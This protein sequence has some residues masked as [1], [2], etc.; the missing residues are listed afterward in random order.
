M[1]QPRRR[2]AQGQQRRPWLPKGLLSE[3]NVKLSLTLSA[4]GAFVSTVAHGHIFTAF[5]FELF[6]DNASVGLVESVAGA[7]ALLTAVPVGL[8]VD[9]V[10]RSKLLRCSAAVGLLAAALGACAVLL[11]PLVATEAAAA[12]R[13]RGAE[14]AGPGRG[15]TAL[16]LAS[17]ALWGAFFNT[18]TSASAALFADSVPQGSRRRD[19]YATKSTLSLMALSAGPLLSLVCTYVLGNEWRLEQMS[20]A[21]LPGFLAMPL[22]CLLLTYFEDVKTP[23]LD[24]LRVGLMKDAKEK[25]PTADVEAGAQQLLPSQT[26]QA[27]AVPYLILT[28]ELIT[29]VGA[30]MTVKFFGLWFKNVF[31]F[32][33]A[34]LAML[35]AATPM[36]IAVAVQSLQRAA[37]ACPC[38]PVPA[39]LAF[40]VSSVGCLLAM[41][42]A[43][44]WRVLVALHLLR[45]ALANCKEPL[46][47]A[48]LADFVPSSQRGR[49][50]AVHSLTGMTWTGSAALGG[51]LCDRYGYGKTFVITACLYLLAALFWLPLI[52]L[53]P[54]EQKKA[55]DS[56][57]E[58]K[59]KGA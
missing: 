8:A 31:N 16:L 15:Y 17:L 45:T 56:D 53:V 48:I 10:A 50:N 55:E 30:G 37:R 26:P 2:A 20:Y 19:L 3:T 34:G 6:G 33:P 47:R 9:K 7:T 1:L 42:W 13:G 51:V 23:Q 59:A 41:T 29:S 54:K 58:E 18:A 40:W 22:M 43:R 57:V 38:G 27:R 49:W 21:L 46:A 32:S 12:G 24:E 25:S 36:A 44:D 11:G 4:L 39:M 14:R 28:A 35:Q 52:R 5:I